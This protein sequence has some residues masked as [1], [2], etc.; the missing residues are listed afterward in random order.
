L[1]Y[2][3]ESSEDVIA[4]RRRRRR[5]MKA[6]TRETD[7]CKNTLDSRKE[8]QGKDKR[9]KEKKENVYESVLL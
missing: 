2:P 1:L 6:T 4:Q 8:T 5:N 7:Y 3:S 9:K